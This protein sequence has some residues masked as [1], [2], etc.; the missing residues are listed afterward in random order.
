MSSRYCHLYKTAGVVV[1][2]FMEPVDGSDHA[3]KIYVTGEHSLE[4]EKLNT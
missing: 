1:I 3:G 4:E 2:W